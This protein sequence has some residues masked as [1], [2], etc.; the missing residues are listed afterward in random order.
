MDRET[1]IS[2]YFQLLK[3]FGMLAAGDIPFGTTQ[4][5]ILNTIR[6]IETQYGVCKIMFNIMNHDRE[7]EISREF[8]LLKK[9]GMLAA[10]MITF[11]N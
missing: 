9:I 10:V 4:V 2:R 5:I 8:Q 6:I 3:K 7:T 11:H 1:K